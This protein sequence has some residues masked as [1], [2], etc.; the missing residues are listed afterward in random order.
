GHDDSRARRRDVVAADEKVLGIPFTLD[1]TKAL[2]AIAVH[3]GDVFRLEHGSDGARVAALDRLAGTPNV[4]DDI[5]DPLRLHLI[6]RWALPPAAGDQAPG[7]FRCRLAQ[8]AWVRRRASQRAAQRD[9]LD[10]PCPLAGRL[11]N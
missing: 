10:K 2:E 9:D 4:V 3:P 11:A 7:W 6:L 5:V 8:C 1:S